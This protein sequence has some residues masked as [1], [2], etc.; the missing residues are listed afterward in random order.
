MPAKT[1]TLWK[2]F[3]A[4]A[5]DIVFIIMFLAAVVGW[6]R[7]ETVKSTKLEVKVEITL[8]K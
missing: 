5:R 6:I 4:N 3:M 8:I 1:E 7:A 2:K